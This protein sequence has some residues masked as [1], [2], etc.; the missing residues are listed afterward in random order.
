VPLDGIEI[1]S[2]AERPDLIRSAHAVEVEIVADVP[3]GSELMT[4]RSYDA[5]RAD[6]IDAPDA[7]PALCL[8]ALVGDQ[9]VGWTGLSAL[10]E[11]G[12]AENQ[13]TGVVHAWRGR[14]IATAL[15]REQAWRAK[16]AGL[17]RI[18]TTNDEVNGPM[19]AVNLR[20]GFEPEP[21]WLSVQGPLVGEPG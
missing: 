2:L 13:L 21:V 18:E 10:A 5:W 3:T 14:G 12:V 1:V 15:K 11:E 7:L 19:R 6:T 16:Q 20:L 17:R 4:P 8:V 9:V